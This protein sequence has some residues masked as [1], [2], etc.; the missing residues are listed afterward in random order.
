MLLGDVVV[1]LR[2]GSRVAR[3]YSLVIAPN[4]RGRGLGRALLLA[5]EQ[6]ALRHRRHWLR[7]EVQVS[8]SAAIALYESA[9]YARFAWRHAYYESG[10]HAWRYEKGL[11]AEG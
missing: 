9:G 2:R 8:N 10:A 6:Y 11:R 7:L 3:L 4:G 1:F 5:A